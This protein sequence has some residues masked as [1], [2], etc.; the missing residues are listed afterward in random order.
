[1]TAAPPSRHAA[2]ASRLDAALAHEAGRDGLPTTVEAIDAVTAAIG[3]L[4]HALGEHRRALDDVQRDHGRLNRALDAAVGRETEADE[5]QAMAGRLRH[6][7]VSAD[8]ELVTLRE[9]IGSAVDTVLAQHQELSQRLGQ[10]D[11]ELLP[12]AEQAHGDALGARAACGAAADHAHQL[13]EVA[14]TAL[15]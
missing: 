5:A 6:D 10:L 9:A 1:M 13:E 2:T 8:H 3:E 7:H 12:A 4:R 14:G 15:E 11:G